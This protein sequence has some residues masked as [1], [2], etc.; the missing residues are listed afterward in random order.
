M[1]QHYNNFEWVLNIE[2]Y[3]M[4]DPEKCR[5]YYVDEAGD[6]TLFDRKGYIIAGNGEGC[7]RFFILGVLDII[8]P[9]LLSSELNDLRTR[10]I[11]DPYLQKVPSMKPENKKTAYAFH[12]KDDI[13]EVRKEVFSILKQSNV[14]F[15]AVVRDKQKVIEYVR[16]RN[17]YNSSYRYN[18]NELYDYMVR[19]L[20]KNIL[21]K[22]DQYKITFSKRGGKDRTIALKY[23]IETA[24]RRFSIKTGSKNNS[25]IDIIA[26]PP[27]YNGG[28]QAVDYFLWALQ[29]FY[30]RKEDRY[31]DYLWEK[32]H[33]VHD[34]DDHRNAKYGVYYTQ[35]MPLTMEALK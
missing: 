2:T 6:A 14:K 21:H 3:L 10:L 32:F 8:E 12:A 17:E 28:L 33:L 15:L 9:V 35:R 34:L 29:R 26:Q 19:I 30:E 27:R 13:P 25:Q 18:A 5:Y 23:A 4:D 16:R 22:D 7:S 1:N 11:N 20:F 31:L 24:R